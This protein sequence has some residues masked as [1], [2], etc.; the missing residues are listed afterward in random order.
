MTTESPNRL[1]VR[2]VVERLGILVSRCVLVGGSA[3]ELLV[4]DGG[5]S[6]PRITLDVDLATKSHTYRERIDFEQELRAVGFVHDTSTGAPS[7]RMLCDG[8]QVDI[9]STDESSHGPTNSWYPLAFDLAEPI[10]IGAS[11]PIRVVTAP[12]F[13]ATKLEAFSNRGHGDFVASHDLEDIIEVVNGRPAIESELSTTHEKVRNF[14]ARQ[15]ETM[16]GDRAF[17]GA[18]PGHLESDSTSQARLEIVL[19]RMRRIALLRDAGPG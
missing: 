2:R 16:L 11:R 15:F 6:A 18:L 10:D 3:T 7:C 17:L 14:V 8:I 12:C 13:L 5:A 1:R 4:S 9:M 19:N